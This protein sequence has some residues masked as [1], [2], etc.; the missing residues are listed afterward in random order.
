MKQKWGQNFLIREHYVHKMLELADIRV[1]AQVLE[2]GPGK[3]ILT[4]QLLQRGAIVTAVEI[5]KS[6][7]D[8]LQEHC[9]HPSLQLV[10]GDV[11]HLSEEQI[12][13]LYPEPYKI[14][15]NLPY[16]SATAILLKILP[17]RTSVKSITVMVQQE[18]AERICAESEAGKK[19]GYL[20]V[21]MALGFE[22]TLGFTVPPSAFNPPPKVNS[23]VIHL[24]SH[25]SGFQSP[26][27]QHF[28]HWLQHLF[29]QK[30]K[31]LINT[32][33]RF[34]PD[35]YSQQE[36]KLHSLLENRRAE[37]LELEEWKHLYQSYQ[38]TQNA[39]G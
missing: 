35:W 18:V 7:H 1:G 19:H 21:A 15:A 30:R 24:V 31:I 32:I 22:R 28:I 23:A 38:M 29:Q 16:E 3:G 4:R 26:Q 36:I 2:I 20:S 27:E 39:G 13:H 14:V 9:P 10:H 25:S 8:Y 12:L 11:M 34:Y 33:K 17:L 37:T 5:D 6:L